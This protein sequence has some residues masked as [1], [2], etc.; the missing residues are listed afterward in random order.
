MTRF[1]DEVWKRGR[2]DVA[3]EIEDLR[4]DHLRR[5]VS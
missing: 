5:G 4:I 3:D 1:I 2:L